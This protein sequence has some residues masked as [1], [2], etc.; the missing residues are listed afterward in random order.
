M[1]PATQQPKDIIEY[2]PLGA[3][4]SIKLSL[5][6]IKNFICIPT[7]SGKVCG[8]RDATRFLMLC[9]SRALN[10][11][12]GDC[13]LQGYDG[14][15]GPEFSLITAHQA[16]LKRAEL[17]TDFDGMESGV[18]VQDELGNVLD[19]V[20]DFLLEKD[21]LLGA[22]CKVHFK[23]RKFPSVDRVNLRTFDK[24]WGRWESDPAGMIVKCC[25]ASALR[26]AFPTKVGGLYL[27]EEIQA[28]DGS[29]D[30]TLPSLPV[31]TTEQPV[32]E[33]PQLEQP[34]IENKVDATPQS[35]IADLVTSNGHDFVDFTKWAKTSG[36]IPDA[37]LDKLTSFDD[38]PKPEAVRLIRAKAGLIDGL[39]R[40]TEGLST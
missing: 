26:T 27:R 36:F 28:R 19:R 34:R 16:F 21:V 35:Q 33:A 20:G 23:S 25:Q 8:D 40:V 7:K 18:I 39:R 11:F 5:S 29:S 15:N 24:K 1:T 3:Q 31:L 6:I 2:V 30:F 13:F 4:D 37:I 17:H 10:P 12:E 14:K 38:I 22:W 9:K 32:V